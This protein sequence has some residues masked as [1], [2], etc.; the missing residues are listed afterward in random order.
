MFISFSAPRTSALS[1]RT[2]QRQGRGRRFPTFSPSDHSDRDRPPNQQDHDPL[3][4]S[5]ALSVPTGSPKGAPPGFLDKDSLLSIVED[6]LRRSGGCGAKRAVVYIGDDSSA[7]FAE[8]PGLLPSEEDQAFLRREGDQQSVLKVAD[9]SP[10]LPPFSPPLEPDN[11]SVHDP[12]VEG[13]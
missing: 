5:L 1:R 3:S 8:T 7:L 12:E 11:A 10:S 13:F 2:L 9:K 4:P 6:V